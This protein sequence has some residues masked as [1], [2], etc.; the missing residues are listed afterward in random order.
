MMRRKIRVLHVIQ[1]LNYGGM[2]RV[3]SDIAFRC[4]RDRFETH[5]K[6]VTA[7]CDYTDGAT[8][9]FGRGEDERARDYSRA[10]R[11]R[12]VFHAA[13]IRADRDFIGFTFLDEVYVCAVR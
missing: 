9:I 3:L 10:T 13:F 6:F 2:E 7:P 12:F 4:D 1:N 5:V 8:G 11:E